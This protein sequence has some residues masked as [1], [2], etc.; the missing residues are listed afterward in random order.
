MVSCCY[1]VGLVTSP[2]REFLNRYKP[3]RPQP[4][5]I[6]DYESERAE[7]LGTIAQNT[8]LHL[9]CRHDTRQCVAF[10]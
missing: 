9:E 4:V 7:K 6:S 10:E 1:A 8:C 3:R 2:V 5:G